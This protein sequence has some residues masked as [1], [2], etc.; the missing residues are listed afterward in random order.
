MFQGTF[1][2]LVTPFATTRSMN[3][4]SNVSSNRR[5][6]Q[7]SPASSR[8]AP[9]ANHHRR[10]REHLRIVELAVKGR[11]GALQ[12]HCRH[13]LEFHRRGG[14]PHRRSRK[15]RRG[16]RPARRALLQQAVAGRTYRHFC[17]IAEATKLPIILYSIPGRCV[18]E[19]SVETV[20]RLAESCPNIV[21]IKESGGTV[22]A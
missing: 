6:R 7:E 13:R 5:S 16:C 8:S 17:K 18:I 1:T 4:P 2:A 11:C 3:R 21:A 19:I 9:P 14:Q 22:D 15:G 12:S 20:A 10:P